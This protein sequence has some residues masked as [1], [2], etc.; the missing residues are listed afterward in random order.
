[1]LPVLMI[2]ALGTAA[3]LRDCPAPAVSALTSVDALAKLDAG[4]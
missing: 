2:L 4:K 3:P 1:M